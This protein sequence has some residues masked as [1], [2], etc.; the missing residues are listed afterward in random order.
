MSLNFALFAPYL[1]A[2]AHSGGRIRIQ[3]FSSALAQIGELSLFACADAKD[4]ARYG[5]DPELD[6]YSSTHLVPTAK[7][8]LPGSERPARVRRCAP[9]EL[10]RAFAEAH[11]RRRFS[12]VIVEHVHA[13]AFACEQAALPWV[14]DEHNIESQYLEAKTRAAGRARLPFQRGELSALERWERRAWQRAS[15]VVCVSEADARVVELESGRAPVVIPNGVRLGQVPFFSPS[16]RS[17]YELLFVGVLGHPPNAAAARYLARE[18]LPRVR[19]VEPRATLTL[20][21]A[22][23]SPDVLALAGEGVQVTGRVANVGP[24][25]ERAA[26]Y[27]NAVQEGAGTSLKVLET[28]AS[29]L[30]LV[31]TAN[32]VRGFALV[33]GEHYLR[34]ESAAQFAQA[35]VSCL[36]ARSTCDGM[37]RRGRE[38]TE[39][40][41]FH[42]LA[43]Q[44]AA[45]VREVAERARSPRGASHAPAKAL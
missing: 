16:Q 34:A 13:A 20:C 15:Q 1:P 25:L 35:I 27:V 32:G 24:Y 10:G 21:G 42:G 45:V 12:A 3:Q 22:D 29:G 11:A 9:K 44:F 2:P 38:F 30:P 4:I 14:L 41:D 31:S 39:S 28:L 6:V 17:G 8:W 33:S 18:V 26:V 37:A 23:P 7:A 19:H 36:A 40:H 43:Q 5:R